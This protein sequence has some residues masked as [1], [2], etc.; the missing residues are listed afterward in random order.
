M[1]GDIVGFAMS[2]PGW[3]HALAEF[4][5]DAGL[6]VFAALFTLAIWRARAAPDRDLALTFAGPVAVAAAYALSEAVKLLIREERPC[7]GGI[8]TIA[9]C[10]PVGDWSFPS[11]HSVIA[12]A[13]AGALVLVWRRLAWLVLPLAAMMAF[14]RVF[15]GVHYPH[16]VAVGYLFGVLM[17]PLLALLTVGAFI[18]VVR[19]ARE[20]SP[21]FRPAEPRSPAR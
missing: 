10:P 6:L 17:A 3:V 4:G 5:T 2:T 15:V 8:A 19:R 11:N 13:S 20:K 7:R 21:W 18:P 16:D 14:S 9:A 12:A 1:Y